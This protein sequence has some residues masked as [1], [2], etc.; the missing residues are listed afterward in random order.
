M[1]K[2]LLAE[3]AEIMDRAAK[4]SN[5]RMQGGGPSMVTYEF[6]CLRD[7]LLGLIAE[8]KGATHG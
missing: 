5:K 6:E 2:E 8:R 4:V 3:L 7:A 1:T